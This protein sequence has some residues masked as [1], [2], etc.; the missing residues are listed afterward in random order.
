MPTDVLVDLFVTL[1]G[2]PPGAETL[3]AFGDLRRLSG[4]DDEDLPR[5]AIAMLTALSARRPHGP[6]LV[7]ERERGYSWLLRTLPEF[8][9][10]TEFITIGRREYLVLH[11]LALAG[12]VD[13]ESLETY[14]VIVWP[15]PPAPA[16]LVLDTFDPTDE[17]VRQWAYAPE[18]RLTPQDE[19]AA[20]GQPRLLPLLI[21]LADDLECPKRDYLVAIC[22]E[23]V[24]AAQ[25]GTYDRALLGRI[26]SQAAT[27]GAADLRAWADDLSYLLEYLDAQG[28]VTSA[29]AREIARLTLRGRYRPGISVHE[30]TLGVWWAFTASFT[31]DG[32]EIDHLYVH[33]GTGALRWSGRRLSLDEL[34]ARGHS[35]VRDE[36][37]R[38]R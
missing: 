10:D 27:C 14:S 5:Y 22:D 23:Y 17:Q 28:P 7:P 24:S 16:V 18:L 13:L 4:R 11:R 19:H 20:I 15:I 26:R 38:V 8:L 21:T 25:R 1:V 9:P 2:E 37:I 12:V 31:S 36:G 30:S 6:Q 29:A 32:H 33:P 35:V 3:A 34:S